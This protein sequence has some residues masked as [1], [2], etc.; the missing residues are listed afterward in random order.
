MLQSL[1]KLDENGTTVRTELLA[2]A[3][4]FLTMV[5]I[6]F[7][8]PEILAETGMDRGA[9]FAA[10]C[11]AAAFGSLVMGIAAN[12]PIAIAPGMGLNAFF[13]YTVV[14]TGGH[15]WEVALGAVFISG[16]IFLILSILPV[17]EWVINA[18]PLSLKKSISAGIGL[19]LAI[20]AFQNAEIIVNHPATMVGVG[21]L[22]TLPVLFSVLCFFLICVLDSRAVPGAIVIGM[23]VTTAVGVMFGLSEFGGIVSAPPDIAPTFFAMDIVGALELGLISVIIAF[24]FVDMFDTAGTLVGVGH[25]AGLLDK[26]GRLPRLNRALYADSGATI[27]GAALGT[28]PA[29]SYIESAAGV[30]AG[31]RTGLTAVTVGVLFLL[32]LFLSP[33][34]E[35]VQSYATAPAL[36]FVAA[37]MSRGLSEIDWDDVT[38]YAPAV[39]TAISM[40]LTFSIATGIGFGFITYAVLKVGAGR[41]DQASVPVLVLAGAF[42]LKFVFLDA[43]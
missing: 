38:E 29:T 2:G 42:M 5:Y 36:L 11:L 26:G 41:T 7:V 35:A 9:A 27:V 33:L 16:V 10:T 23:L 19:F 30:R 4:T 37:L 6:I 43:Q 22:T 13:T 40:P 32:C 12:Y 28:S 39:V 8:N 14:I 18:I 21:H 17:R 25:R 24:L 15:S 1:F 3:T 34:A 20:I 31:G